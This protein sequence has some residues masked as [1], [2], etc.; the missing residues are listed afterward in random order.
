M[1]VAQAGADL[2]QQ[3][4]ACL[5]DAF[6]GGV[7]GRVRDRQRGI[8]LPRL[9]VDLHQIFGRSRHRCKGSSEGD[10]QRIQAYTFKHCSIFL[11]REIG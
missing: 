2:R 1:N 6:V 4:R 3:C 8:G 11:K 7:L 5:V 9:L 10:S